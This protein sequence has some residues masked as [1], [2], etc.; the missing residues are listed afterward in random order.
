M[1]INIKNQTIEWNG[2]HTANVYKNGVEVD[3]FTFS[4]E[5]SKVKPMDF[6]SATLTH[7]EYQDS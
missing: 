5:K 1:K 6:L 7:L 4:F 3:V 2:N